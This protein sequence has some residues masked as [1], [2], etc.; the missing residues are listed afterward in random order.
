[1]L[2]SKDQEILTHRDRLGQTPLF[3]AVRQNQLDLLKQI[4]LT[5]ELI[6]MV[7]DI[8]GHTILFYAAACGH[9]RMC[10]YLVKKGADLLII[11]ECGQN[12]LSYTSKMPKFHKKAARIIR[13]LE[14]D[15]NE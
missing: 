4:D 7:D 13:K 15:P 8:A 3:A 9:E 1:M 14:Y 11:D 5:K 12:I 2:A 10:K 6:N